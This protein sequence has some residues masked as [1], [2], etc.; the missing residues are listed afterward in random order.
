MIRALAIFLASAAIGFMLV[1]WQLPNTIMNT[2]MAR[3]A[4]GSQDGRTAPPLPDDKARAIV[5]PSPDLAYVLC[6]YDL[7]KGPLAVT[8]NPPASLPYWSVAAYADNSDNFLVINDRDA[9]HAHSVILLSPH[10]FYILPPLSSRAEAAPSD[11]GIVLFRGLMAERNDA[12]L[13]QVQDSV[14][15]KTLSPA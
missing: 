2:L 10:R 6:A 15:C 3:A 13:K 11:R 4:A 7:S 12:V 1:T 5:L 14:S 8:F 9:S